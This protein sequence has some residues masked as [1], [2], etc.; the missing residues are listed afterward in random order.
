MSSRTLPVRPV[1]V[2]SLP[3]TG[4]ADLN[5]HAQEGRRKCGGVVVLAIGLANEQGFQLRAGYLLMASSPCSLCA[6]NSGHWLEFRLTASLRKCRSPSRG[7][8]LNVGLAQAIS[9]NQF[10]KRARNSY[11]AIWAMTRSSRATGSSVARMACF[12]SIER[13]RRE[14][15]MSATRPKSCS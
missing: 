2:F 11:A 14:A 10:P 4:S 1:A 7:N 15:M 9:A 12:F 8:W 6:I 5:R 13:E 3:P